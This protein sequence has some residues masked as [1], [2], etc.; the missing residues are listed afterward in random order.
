M[1]CAGGEGGSPRV[2][3]SRSVSLGLESTTAGVTGLRSD[4][5]SSE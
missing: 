4:V 3:V 1:L 2:P 5:A